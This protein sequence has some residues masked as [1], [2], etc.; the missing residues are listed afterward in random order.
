MKRNSTTLFLMSPGATTPIPW[1]NNAP[2]FS[3]FTEPTLSVLRQAWQE[4][5]DSGEL[6]EIIPDPEPV[7]EPL[8]PNWDA[9]NLYLFSDP[10][11]ILYGIATQSLNPYLVPALVE[12]YG[13]VAELGLAGS[14]FATYWGAFC[15]TA[16]VTSGD[17]ELWADAAEINNLPA[18]FVSLIRN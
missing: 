8:V 7:V 16:A 5:V 13:K 1:E 6:L 10:Q 14:A 17:K 18:E 3:G 2:D 15:A 4:F 11:F 9:F 12:R